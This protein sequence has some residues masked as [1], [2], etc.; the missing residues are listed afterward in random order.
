MTERLP[1]LENATEDTITSLMTVDDE[2]KG[3]AKAK[4]MSMYCYVSNS[5]TI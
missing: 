2:L 1:H 4:A 5:C 3:T